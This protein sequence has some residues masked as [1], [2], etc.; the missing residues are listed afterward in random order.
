LSDI[1][2]KEG[3]LFLAAVID[4]FSRRVVGVAGWSM[5]PDMER[6]LVIM[7]PVFP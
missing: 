1:A 7:I 4:L 6:A 3:W 5:R 2:T